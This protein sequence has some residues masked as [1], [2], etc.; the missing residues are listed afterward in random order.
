[1]KNLG[2]VLKILKLVD[3]M[4]FIE[5]NIQFRHTKFS[6][7]SGPQNFHPKCPIQGTHW[8]GEDFQRSETSAPLMS[9]IEKNIQYSG[10]LIIFIQDHPISSH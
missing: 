1:M 6:S 8:Q 5:K 9:F 3:R 10:P 4:S 7:N 2:R